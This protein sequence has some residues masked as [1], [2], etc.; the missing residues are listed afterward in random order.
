MA[1]RPL[2]ALVTAT[3]AA[4]LVLTAA[5]EAAPDRRPTPVAP[6]LAPPTPEL[7]WVGRVLVPV[8]ARRAPSPSAKA[9]TV[10]QPIAPLGQGPTTLLITRTVVKEGRRWAEVLLPIRPNG[11]RGWVPAD[12]LRIRS[13]PLRI[14]IDVTERRLTLF[15]SNRPIL[16]APVA[17]GKVGTETPR[18]RNFAIAE[19]IPTN[20]PG[21]FLG[22]IVFP[23]TGY[24]EKLNE[25]AGGNGRVAIHGTSLPEL[26][27]SAA[28]NGCIRMRNRDVVRMSRLVRPGTPV[29]IRT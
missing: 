18:S 11:A 23:I 6:A 17:V 9:R 1:R 14:V 3:C 15:R 12:V 19:M 22:P 20:T 7:A 5:A 27:G 25:F 24:S 8:T 28:S 4:G 26:I 10:L 16:R 21:A 29:K 13:T 2:A